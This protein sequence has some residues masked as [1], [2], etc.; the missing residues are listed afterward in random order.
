TNTDLVSQLAAKTSKCKDL[1][2]ECIYLRKQLTNRKSAIDNPSKTLVIGSS[3]IRDF[4]HTKIRNTDV[5]CI[6]GGKIKDVHK[7]ITELGKTTGPKPYNRVILQI[8][9][10]DS[11]QN[12]ASA[13]SIVKDYKLMAT[14]AKNI[15]DEIHVSS[16]TPRTDNKQA[17]EVIEA[18]N[19][20]L[21]VMCD[22]D[23]QFTYIN[24]DTIFRLQ[25]G[26]I[27]D[28]YLDSWG[29]H[30]TKAGSNKLAHNM[31]L[32]TISDDITK[33]RQ[34]NRPRPSPNNHNNRPQAPQNVMGISSSNDTDGWQT[35]CHKKHNNNSSCDNSSS[36]YQSSHSNAPNKKGNKPACFK[37]GES[38]HLASSCWHPHSV[39]CYL[40]N[41]LGHKQTKCPE[42]NVANSN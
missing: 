37:C 9:S 24:N 6:R 4:D 28:G 29:L 3:I 20:E 2:E 12:D 32:D 34:F 31:K 18:V 5:T 27:N 40:C 13:E 39:R 23:N 1:D 30:L 33:P 19:A 26:S 15:S 16:I 36:T 17:Q 8:A 21:Q 25:D 22:N 11:S 38:S 7:E 10:N 41:S 42:F 35:V 14:G